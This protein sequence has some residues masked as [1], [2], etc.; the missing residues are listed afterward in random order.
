LAITKITT[1]N[2]PAVN[3]EIIAGH[4]L[5]VYFICGIESYFVDSLQQD[6]IKTIPE[7]LRDFNLDIFYGNETDLNK[8]LEVAK[9]YPMMSEKRMVVLRDLSAVTSRSKLDT[10]QTSANSDDDS[11][12]GS[13]NSL[14]QYLQQPNPSTILI[15]TDKKA[16]GNT[17]LG[18]I[19]GNS[20]TIGYAKFDA[21]NETQLPQWITKWAHLQFNTVI[22]PA[23]S[24]LI[25]QRIGND[26]LAITTEI[27]KIKAGKKEGEA[28]S[29]TDIDMHVRESRVVNIFDFKDAVNK[30]NLDR[31]LTMADQILQTSKTNET[32]EVLRVIAFFYSYYT[33]IWQ[34]LRLTQKGIPT[35][36]IKQKI[37]VKNDYYYTNL[38][39][40]S[41]YYTYE[42][43]HMCF[44]AVM[45]ADRAIKGFSK[46]SAPDILFIFVRRIC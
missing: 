45:D 30:R 14:L 41:K 44:E 13:L 43:L 3:K 25:V 24:Q 46:L 26:L 19:V 20:P 34:I 15:I 2:Y 4:V 12:A 33:N 31:S 21:I 32:G 35:V 6:L 23:A 22:D 28:I 38:V 11:D 40:E 29:L 17:K 37:G 39:S 5:P 1:D 27:A 36:E 9:S 10:E 42:R 18:K 16:P 8:V 7:D